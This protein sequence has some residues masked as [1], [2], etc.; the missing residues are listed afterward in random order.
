MYRNL[1]K[2]SKGRYFIYNFQL[3]TLNDFNNL[4]KFKTKIVFDLTKMNLNKKN[5]LNPIFFLYFLTKNRPQLLKAKLSNMFL[6]IRK[7]NLIES[8]VTLSDLI[9]IYFSKILFD[10]FKN[11]FYNMLKLK[12]Q[13]FSK[14]LFF[15]FDS[16]FRVWQK[17]F[18]KMN[19]YSRFIF[20]FSYYC[21]KKQS[22]LMS[23]NL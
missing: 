17:L 23:L 6:K 2:I 7:N 14:S 9:N 5:L 1:S 22:F 15:T 11:D 4:L 10:N 8:F 18:G 19:F 3:K 16:K 20:I 21:K 13:N 12:K